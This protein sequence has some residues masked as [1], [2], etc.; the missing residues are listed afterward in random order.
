MLN[1]FKRQLIFFLI[2]NSFI[3]NCDLKQY[4]TSKELYEFWYNYKNVNKFFDLFI[5]IQI[6]IHFLISSSMLKIKTSNNT[7][8][9]Y[10]IL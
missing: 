8:F 1:R 6:T 2:Q 10:T 3:K 5:L 9:E 7:F 4:F